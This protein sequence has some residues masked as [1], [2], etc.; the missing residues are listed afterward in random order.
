MTRHHVIVPPHPKRPRTNKEHQYVDAYAQWLASMTPKQRADAE[1]MGL[2]KQGLASTCG[3]ST[4]RYLR[5]KEL[6]PSEYGDVDPQ[7]DPFVPPATHA[8]DEPVRDEARELACRVLRELAH[9]LE[10]HS[11]FSYALC[12]GLG[13]TRS[14][15]AGAARRF[16]ISPQR[17]DQLC[18]QVDSIL[19][20]FSLT[21]RCPKKGKGFLRKGAGDEGTELDHKTAERKKP[22][23]SDSTRK[24][25]RRSQMDLPL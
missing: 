7:F 25:G 19:A 9:R 11:S 17:L 14:H 13:L 2:G 4:T 1:A 8:E 18:A 21:D 16:K 10:G 12:R 24:P 15:H 23:K 5:G 6:D 3:V 22:I 20:G